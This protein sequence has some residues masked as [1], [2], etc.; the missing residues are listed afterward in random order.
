[1]RLTLT[2]DFSCTLCPRILPFFYTA[3]NYI[4]MDQ[5]SLT[6]WEEKTDS[7]DVIK[8]SPT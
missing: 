8:M 6:K 5:A 4:E 7:T 2:C 1:M 3:K